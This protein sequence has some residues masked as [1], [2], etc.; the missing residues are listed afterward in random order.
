MYLNI[1]SEVDFLTGLV[2]GWAA[3]VMGT[4]S[5][6]V[7]WCTTRLSYKW[8]VLQH[9]D[10]TLGILHTH[11]ISGILG[12][13]LTGLFAHPGLCNMFLPVTNSRGAFY[14]GASG[15]MQFVKQL[16]GACFVIGW[17][18]IITSVIMIFIR[19]F[20]PLRL[21]QEELLAGDIALHGEEAYAIQGVQKDVENG[22]ALNQI[23]DQR[24]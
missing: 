24:G 17:N 11:A 8:V 18:V 2:Q 6:S 13:V 3:M 12:G 4:V 1:I 16:I 10:D 19:V 21:S 7:P 15:G 20:V 23:H 14:G 22:H 9:V 5:G